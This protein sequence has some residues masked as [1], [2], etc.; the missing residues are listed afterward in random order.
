MTF[1]GL[2]FILCYRNIYVDFEAEVDLK[3]NKWASKFLV[4][5]PLYGC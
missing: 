3:E 2:C 5:L 4:L 1:F